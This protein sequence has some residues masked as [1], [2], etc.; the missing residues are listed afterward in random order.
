LP[1]KPGAVMKGM[2]VVVQVLL[3]KKLVFLV[4]MKNEA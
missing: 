1:E 2:M 4:V 3:A